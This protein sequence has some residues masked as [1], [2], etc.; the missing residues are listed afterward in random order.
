LRSPER[1]HLIISSTDL[2]I[3]QCELG[4]FDQNGDQPQAKTIG[5][6]F[7][8]AAP[9]HSIICTATAAH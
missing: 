1:R 5:A 2:K 7:V 9:P 3:G 6:A 4:K 8:P